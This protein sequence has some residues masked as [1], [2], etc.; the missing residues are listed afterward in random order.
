MQAH[1]ILIFIVLSCL[2]HEAYA[3]DASLRG[4]VSSM[5]RQNRNANRHELARLRDLDDLKRS[6]TEGRLVSVSDTD[7]YRIDAYLGY[8]DADNAA[9]YRHARP[10]TKRF[11]D[12][13]LGAGHLATGERFTIT[14]LVRTKVYERRLTKSGANTISGR[15]WWKQSS[16]LTG[17]AVDISHKEMSREAKRWLERRLLQLERQG[18]IEAT[19]EHRSRCYHIMVFPEYGRRP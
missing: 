14:S 12:T 9:W 15:A 6:V 7:A 13:E 17:A 10:W 8:L 16:H 11:L 2:P 3:E 18:V 5:K 1:R 4:G 19:K